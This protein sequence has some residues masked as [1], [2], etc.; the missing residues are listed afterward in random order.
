MSILITTYEGT[1]NHPLPVGATAMASTASAA[2]SFVLLDSSNSLSD[3]RSSFTQASLPYPGYHAINPPS[4]HPSNFRSINPGDPSK[5]IVLDLTNNNSYDP[6]QFPISSPSYPSAQQS[7]AWMQSRPSYNNHNGNS[8]PSNLFPSRRGSV[9][10]KGWKS[11]EDNKS[12]AENVTAIASDPKFRVAVAAAISSLINKESHTTHSVGPPFGP[13]DGESGSSSS[14]MNWVHE[15]L[16]GN[17]KPIIRHS[18]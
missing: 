4:S 12:L 18:P 17:G 5:G 9:D 15:S 10:E 7:F 16:S 13:R 6:P 3:G 1:H 8:V 2:A 11:N 14:N